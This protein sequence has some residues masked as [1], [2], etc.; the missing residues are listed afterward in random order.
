MKGLC[1]SINRLEGFNRLCG[2][3]GLEGLEEEARSNTVLFSSALKP[4]QAEQEGA[5]EARQQPST[6]PLTANSD[7]TVN[8]SI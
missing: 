8:G 4:E 6:I 5:T 2:L 1:K 7:R 3:E